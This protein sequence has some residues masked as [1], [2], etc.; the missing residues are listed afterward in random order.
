MAKI[1]MKDTEIKEGMSQ[2]G[3]VYWTQSTEGDL[4]NVST[5][6]QEHLED[7]FSLCSSIDL[8]CLNMITIILLSTPFS[9][10][11]NTWSKQI[12]NKI[13]PR[14]HQKGLKINKKWYS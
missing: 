8:F 12:N 9:E 13:I 10:A 2:T 7:S 11:K 4:V 3:V 5:R 14:P 1:D 6:L